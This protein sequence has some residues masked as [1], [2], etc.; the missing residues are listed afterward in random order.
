M[1]R[2]LQVQKRRDAS[3]WLLICDKDALAIHRCKRIRD[4]T[5]RRRRRITRWVFQLER[6]KI[7]KRRYLI[8][9]LFVYIQISGGNNKSKQGWWRETHW[10][11]PNT[12]RSS[13]CQQVWTIKKLD[14]TSFQLFYSATLFIL[15]TFNE[16]VNIVKGHTACGKIV[17]HSN[18][19]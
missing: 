4:G 18:C 16:S 19:V 8:T 15:K 17:A 6:R 12:A 14:V 5:A 10:L 3:V 9:K 1:I 2:A 7:K 11:N 13:K